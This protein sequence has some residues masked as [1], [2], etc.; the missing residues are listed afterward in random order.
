LQPTNQK[1]FAEKDGKTHVNLL[2]II[3]APGSVNIR[4]SGKELKTWGRSMG[5]E[6]VTK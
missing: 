3:E 4:R 5:S 1:G 2:A 6:A